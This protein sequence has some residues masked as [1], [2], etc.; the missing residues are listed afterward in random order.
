MSHLFVNRWTVLLIAN[1]A[2]CCVLSFYQQSDGAQPGPKPPFA[3]SVAQRDEMITHLRE[4]QA[5][6]K[7]QNALLRGG[8]IQ[9]IVAE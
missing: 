2:F 8:K 1:V 3:N 7:E 4:I 6:L 5:L 9:V